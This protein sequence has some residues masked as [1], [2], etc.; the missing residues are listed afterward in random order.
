MIQAP[1]S[2]VGLANLSR[3]PDPFTWLL[4]I[5]SPTGGGLIDPDGGVFIPRLTSYS[6]QLAWN[7]MADG[8]D[9][10]WQPYPIQIGD[11]EASS[12]GD[13][14]GMTIGLGNA[15]NVL[16][17]Y[18]EANDRL[19]DHRVILHLVNVSQIADASAHVAF[20]FV[21]AQSEISEDGLALRV[22]SGAA[23]EQDVPLSVVTDTCRWAYRGPGCFFIGD[24]GDADLGKCA[25]TRAACRLRGDWEAAN[26]LAVIHP[27]Q[28]GGIATAGGAV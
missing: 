9:Q 3:L 27:R 25:F 14:E 21:V 12:E 19:R 4:E 16:L 11:I 24:P 22:A 28:F 5:Q 10:L 17:A 18:W 20:R 1:S 23:A 15:A 2:F 6:K 26:G 8:T 7:K 13:L